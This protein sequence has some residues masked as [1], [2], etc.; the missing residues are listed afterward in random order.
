MWC[1]FRPRCDPISKRA[2]SRAVRS[3]GTR[4]AAGCFWGGGSVRGHRPS[5]GGAPRPPSS[6]FNELGGGGALTP[7]YFVFFPANHAPCVARRR[8]LLHPP[9]SSARIPGYMWG[10]LFPRAPATEAPLPGVGTESAAREVPAP[11]ALHVPGCA[12]RRRQA[13]RTAAAGG[14]CHQVQQ[15]GCTPS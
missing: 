10:F 13:K 8:S 1:E 7:R 15:K 4:A 2:F 5:W 6:S 3:S 12:A 9:N 11:A 14:Q